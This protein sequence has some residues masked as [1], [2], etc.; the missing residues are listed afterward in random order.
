MTQKIKEIA[1]II[2]A[3]KHLIELKSQKKEGALPK[4]LA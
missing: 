1:V 2:T 3:R 4:Y